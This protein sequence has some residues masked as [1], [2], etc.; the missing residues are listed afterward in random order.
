MA[1]KKFNPT[2]DEKSEQT[3]T[4]SSGAETGTSPV[5]DDAHTT[6][7]VNAQAE[8]GSGPAASGATTSATSMGNSRTSSTSA[9]VGEY[10][11]SA[12]SDVGV[13]AVGPSGA[14][15]ASE[16]GSTSVG[17]EGGAAASNAANSTTVDVSERSGR[18]DEPV[19]GG[20]E[21]PHGKTDR[22][23]AEGDPQTE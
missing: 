18:A 11:A 22:Q 4:G 6:S 16:V 21:L 23:P 17:P 19:Q 14:A 12:A 20:T 1:L 15:S 10:G 13:A 3:G 2:D 9:A 5:P 7:A 8:Q